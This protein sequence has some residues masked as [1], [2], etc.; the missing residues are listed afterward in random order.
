MDDFLCELVKCIYS[1]IARDERIHN[2]YLFFRENELFKIY[3]TFSKKGRFFIRE[4]V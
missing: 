4:N 3:E 2:I 1:L